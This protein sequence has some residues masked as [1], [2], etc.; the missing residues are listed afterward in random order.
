MAKRIKSLMKMLYDYNKSRECPTK[1]QCDI[2]ENLIVDNF[3][4]EQIWQEIE[5]Q[6]DGVCNYL[7][8]D[9]ARILAKKKLIFKTDDRVIN[10]NKYNLPNDC[11]KN[12]IAHEQHS[13]ESV[14]EKDFKKA[15]KSNLTR[16]AKK[17]SVVDDRFFKLSE[18][19]DFLKE[20]EN[21]NTSDG[22]EESV[23]LFGDDLADSENAL[24][25]NDFF[26]LP[27]DAVPSK[28]RKRKDSILILD[29]GAR[30]KKKVSFVGDLDIDSD[31]SK[32]ESNLGDDLENLGSND[33]IE[34]DS[35][36]GTGDA[37]EMAQDEEEVDDG[38]SA[39]KSS[40]ESRQERLKMRI[41][42][43]EEEALKE[44]PWQLKGE[45]TAF[46]RPQNSL[47]EEY[48]EFD[49]A[50]RPA[51]IITEKVTLKL[52]DVIR[53]RIKDKVWDDVVRK[54]KPVEDP[55][56]YKKRLILNQE[57]S[58]LSLSEIYEKEYLREKSDKAKDEEVVDEE[59]TEHVQI[60]KVMKALFAKL[61]ALSNFHYTPKQVSLCFIFI[62]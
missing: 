3:D 51:P 9:V 11:I 26:D 56:E 10:G 29:E 50:S 58:K 40:Y 13:S 25:Y 52:E 30:K 43:L 16:K 17:P 37:E 60:K 7:V 1:K 48:V 33:E 35:V 61:D 45:V 32:E 18:M 49:V 23:D 59:S 20:M 36:E 47:L 28:N 8:S 42:A 4:E 54:I 15:E 2:L 46:K 62:I 31:A 38:D 14:K 24:H 44:K 21:E 27:D 5:L 57:K 39:I 41:N 19:E 53:Q 6:N 55:K 34:Y 22:S 12:E